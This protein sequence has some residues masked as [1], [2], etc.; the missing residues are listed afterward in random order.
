MM[1]VVGGVE[2]PDAFKGRVE[3]GQYHDGGGGGSGDDGKGRAGGEE[4][5]AAV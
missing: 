5:K 3:G 2:G 4:Q 1:L